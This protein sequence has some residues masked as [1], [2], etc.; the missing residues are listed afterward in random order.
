M[1]VYFCDS[2]SDKD[3]NAVGRAMWDAVN[4]LKAAEIT[5]GMPRDKAIDSFI[6]CH[7]KQKREIEILTKENERLRNEASKEGRCHEVTGVKD[8]NG[9]GTPVLHPS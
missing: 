8:C 1:E 7:A 9:V 4:A 6:E 2:P 3:F 5:D